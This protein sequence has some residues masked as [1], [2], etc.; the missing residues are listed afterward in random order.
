MIVICQKRTSSNK[1]KIIGCSASYKLLKIKLA[2]PLAT[3]LAALLLTSCSDSNGSMSFATSEEAINEYRAFLQGLRKKDGATAQQL[4]QSIK[5]WRTLDDSVKSCLR[6][7]TVNRHH[8]ATLG[9]YHM[10]GDSIR[11]ELC[12]LVTSKQRS[13]HDVLYIKE[14]ASSY[15]DDAGLREIA[16]HAAPFFASLDSLPINTEGGKQQVLKRYSLFLDKT[17]KHGFRYDA[18]L[19]QFFRDEEIHYRSFLHFYSDMMGE[20]MRDI[21]VKTGKCCR[22][23]IHAADRGILPSDTTLVYLTMRTNHRL[24][25]NTQAALKEIKSGR[26]RQIGIDTAYMLMLIKPFMYLDDLAVTLLTGKEK[27]QLYAIAD[28]IPKVMDCL[29]RSKRFDKQRMADIP[30]IILK[31]YCKQL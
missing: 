4:A 14:H 3:V 22:Q 6:R 12:R 8:P 2:M 13:F 31:L 25:L 19:F 23:L 15:A 24:L 5:S 29:H 7:D 11:D 9:I 26:I 28:D 1:K 27:Q 10:L 17:Q 16:S 18:D 21:T 20:D 30:N